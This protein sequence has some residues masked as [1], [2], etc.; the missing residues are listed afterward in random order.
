LTCYIYICIQIYIGD[1]Y[2]ENGDCLTDDDLDDLEE[3]LDSVL[4]AATRW[5]DRRD[6]DPTLQQALDAVSSS[7]VLNYPEYLDYSLKFTIVDEFAEDPNGSV[8]SCCIFV[9]VFLVAFILSS[10]SFCLVAVS[11][12]G[13]TI[14]VLKF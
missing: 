9:F 6:V 10:M 13:G 4:S 12:R 14:L 3:D 1:L 7:L 2:N 8:C 11:L 5:A